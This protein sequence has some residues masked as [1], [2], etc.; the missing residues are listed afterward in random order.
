MVIA[1]TAATKLPLEVGQLGVG[2]PAV[3]QQSGG[4]VAP[5]PADAQVAKTTCQ[6]RRSSSRMA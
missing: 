1:A 5:L 3:L 6:A 2:R 4:D